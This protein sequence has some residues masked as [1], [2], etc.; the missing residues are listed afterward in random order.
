[1]TII[2][3]KF[4]TAASRWVGVGPY[5]AMFPSRFA[6]H[7]IATHSKI[8]DTIIDPF[9]GR[10]TSIFSAATSGR[11]ALGVEINPVGWVFAVTKLKPAFHKKALVRAEEINELSGRFRRAAQRMP[12]F[13]L[14]CFSPKVLAYLLAARQHLEWRTSSIDRTLMA[15]LLIDLHGKRENALS[16]QLRQTKCMAPE[17]AVRWWNKRKMK[18]PNLDPVEYLTKKLKWRYA[19]GLP[20][21]SESR[22]FLGDST[23]RI[24]GLSIA[25]AR[26]APRGAKLLFTSPP[27]LGITN[28]HYDQ[29]LRLWLLGG[30]E[31]PHSSGEPHR[32]RFTN[33]TQYHD[34]LVSSFTKSRDLLASDATIYVR[35]DRRRETSSITRDVLKRIF[36]KHVICRRIRPLIGLTQT[37]LFGNGAPDYGEVDLVLTPN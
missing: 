17:Y 11:H 13:Y 5:Y 20:E 9:A 37:R 19:H 27:Y 25:T 18:P 34:L 22:V 30:T 2:A 21:I 32:S 6:D 31:L 7:V 35:T 1:M 10:G 16:N 15:I 4:S 14:R 26:L 24:R 33:P 29:W 3:G 23:K 12:E 8:G 28:Y 36:P